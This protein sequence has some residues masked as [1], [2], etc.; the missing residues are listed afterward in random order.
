MKVLGVT[1]PQPEKL[2]AVDCV[3][4]EERTTKSVS[5]GTLWKGRKSHVNVV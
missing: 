2:R 4:T 5:E 3:P 1:E